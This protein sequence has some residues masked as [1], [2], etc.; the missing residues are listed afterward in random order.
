MIEA[1]VLEAALLLAQ[2]RSSSALQ[3]RETA[4]TPRSSSTSRPS[5]PAPALSRSS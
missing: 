5:M 1:V 3:A 4:Y 2:A